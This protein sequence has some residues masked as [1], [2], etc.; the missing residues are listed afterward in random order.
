MAQP[1]WKPTWSVPAAMRAVRAAVVVPS[2]FAVTY[3]VIGDSQM[4]LFATFGGF[5]TLVIAKSD[6]TTTVARTARIAA[7]TDQTGFHQ[8]CAM[9]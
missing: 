5:A 3:K 2:L 9:P 7:G 1:W 8:G 6:G 4:A